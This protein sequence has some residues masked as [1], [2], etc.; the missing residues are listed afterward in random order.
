MSHLFS[1]LKYFL[2]NEIFSVYLEVNNGHED[3]LKIYRDGQLGLDLRVGHFLYHLLSG[4]WALTKPHE[5][6]AQS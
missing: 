4:Q 5:P 6:W 2:M 3:S 1:P